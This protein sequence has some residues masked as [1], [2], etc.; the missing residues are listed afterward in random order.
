MVSMTTPQ[1]RSLLSL[2]RPAPETTGAIST[3]RKAASAS[4]RRTRH[5][6][7]VR[8][9]TRRRTAPMNMSR[10]VSASFC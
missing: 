10:S 1:P 4:L 9:A 3:I 6:S 7:T 2:A 5:S 8:L